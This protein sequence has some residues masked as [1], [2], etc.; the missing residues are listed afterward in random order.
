MPTA[1]GAVD[2]LTA[3]QQRVRLMGVGIRKSTEQ[4]QKSSHFSADLV[5]M[6]GWL[7]PIPFRTRQIVLDGITRQA[8]EVSNKNV[9]LTL[10]QKCRD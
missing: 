10:N 9:N 3:Q 1:L 5:A 8:Q 7:H 4:D 6:A 2:G